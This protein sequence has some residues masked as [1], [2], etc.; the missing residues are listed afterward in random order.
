MKEPSIFTRLMGNRFVALLLLFACGTV[1]F[2][3]IVGDGSRWLGIA[4]VITFMQTLA[5]IG[6]V[7][8]Y[9]TWSAKW[10]AMNAPLGE[11]GRVRPSESGDRS[12]R[13]D[14]SPAK[15]PGRKRLRLVTAAIL[16]LAIPL[17]VGADV[18]RASGPL[19]CFW[20]A[21]CLY[22]G[23]RLVRKMKRGLRHRKQEPPSQKREMETPFV[24][25]VLDKPASS[26]SRAEAMRDL[27]DYCA[28]LL[29][30]G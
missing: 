16:S 25:C 5:A 17:Y 21:T 1:I 4:A 18:D 14:A 12:P 15:V 30:R 3:W 13:N 27:P 2:Q 11:T 20:L 24:T 22:V 19:A 28:R 29:T 10:L 26:P 7:S 9:K 8:R 6:K 23:Y